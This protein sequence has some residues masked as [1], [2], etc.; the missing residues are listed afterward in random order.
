MKF[1]CSLF[2][3]LISVESVS[4]QYLV[5]TYS[6]TVSDAGVG[7]PDDTTVYVYDVDVGATNVFTRI[8]PYQGHDE[9]TTDSSAEDGAS[10]D[11]YL[12]GPPQLDLVGEDLT[13]STYV[14]LDLGSTLSLHGHSQFSASSG[15][16]SEGVSYAQGEAAAGF[17]FAVSCD[18]VSSG[19]AYCVFGYSGGG[20]IPY[21]ASAM[22]TLYVNGWPMLH[23]LYLG[24]EHYVVDTYFVTYSAQIDGNYYIPVE[25][26]DEVYIESS[27]GASSIYQGI[28]GSGGGDSDGIDLLYSVSMASGL[29]E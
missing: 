18:V 21:N 10:R 15:A 26:G 12:P 8:N 29:P 28:Q 20:S 3:L 1:A 27:G 9:G 11:A 16:L 7:P 22:T 2:L 25:N 19:S 24:G 23:H 4:A 5:P 17:E 6:W 14:D 13:A